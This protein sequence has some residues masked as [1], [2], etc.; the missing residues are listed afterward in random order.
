[1]IRI[2]VAYARPDRQKI[3]VVKVPS[4]TTMI[5]AV[6]QS[7]IL[8]EFPEIDLA[9]AHMGIYSKLVAKPDSQVLSDGDRIELYRPLQIDPKQARQNRARK[10]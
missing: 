1:M 10:V 6:K 8:D 4:G 3:L 2:E 5:D 9:K 7:G